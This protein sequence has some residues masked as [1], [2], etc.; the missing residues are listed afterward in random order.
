MV[1]K[2]FQVTRIGIYACRPSACLP[3]RSKRNSI[4]LF[5]GQNLLP[6]TFYDHGRAG[7]VAAS[8]DGESQ[9]IG[10]VL[11]SW[12]PNPSAPKTGLARS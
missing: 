10:W 7:C 4:L 8:K 11:R 1:A 6:A 9:I 5:A 12:A 3:V 2:V